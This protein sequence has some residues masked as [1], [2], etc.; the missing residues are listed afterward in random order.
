VLVALKGAG[1]YNIAFGIES[2]NQQIL[3]RLGKGERLET[4]LQAIRLANAR[5]IL[6]SG[7]FVLGLPGDTEETVRESMDFAVKS[8]LSDASFFVATPYPGTRLWNEVKDRLPS[9]WTDFDQDAFIPVSCTE[10]IT[11]ARLLDLVRI[12]NR[13]FY[14]RPKVILHIARYLLNFRS[15]GIFKNKLLSYLGLRSGN[16]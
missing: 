16:I 5:G 13:R 7:F 11:P 14:F 15:L 2:G 3:D 9:N 4:V 1:V 10:Y 6:T 12:A 8:G